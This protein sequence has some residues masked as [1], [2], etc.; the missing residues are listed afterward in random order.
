MFLIGKSE[1]LMGDKLPGVGVGAS[2][3]RAHA[4]LHA[5]THV[6]VITFAYT[7]SSQDML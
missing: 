7:W 6:E 5:C 1:L 2:Y 4:G 3:V